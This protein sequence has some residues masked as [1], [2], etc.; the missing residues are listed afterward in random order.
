MTEGSL[1]GPERRRS[2][3]AII[4]GMFVI[5]V[6][7]GL[8]TPGIALMLEERGYAPKAAARRVLQLLGAEPCPVA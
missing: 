3:A 6:F 2:L 5:G 1:S 8:F 4:L 7:W